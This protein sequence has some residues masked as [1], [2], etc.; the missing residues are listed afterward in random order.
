MF[1]DEIIEKEGL[2][3]ELTEFQDALTISNSGSSK[4]AL[5]DDDGNR[6][7]YFN[8][9]NVEL[10]LGDSSQLSPIRWGKKKRRTD[11]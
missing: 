1:V 5:S 9:V 6:C 11:P 7:S 8:S 10:V 2:D 4:S 3:M